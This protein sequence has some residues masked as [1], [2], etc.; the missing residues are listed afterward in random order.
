[1]VSN[2]EAY[3]SQYIDHHIA[4]HPR[5]GSVVMSRQNL[6]Q[7]GKHPWVMHGCLDSASAFAT[8]AMQLFGPRHRDVDRVALAFGTRLANRRL[9]H[10]VSCASIQSSPTTLGPRESASW[11]FFALYDPDHPVASADGDLEKLDQVA[12]PDPDDIKLATGV[13]RRSVLRDAP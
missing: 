6:A 2:N 13:T 7:D 5:F 11:R 9:Q 1:F 3:A 10:E 12:W 8:D 4:R